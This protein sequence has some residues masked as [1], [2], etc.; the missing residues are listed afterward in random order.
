MYKQRWS[1]HLYSHCF[2]KGAQRPCP[3]RAVH[4]LIKW[5]S[6]PKGH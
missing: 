5:R 6:Q 3:N 1:C 4:K 2:Y